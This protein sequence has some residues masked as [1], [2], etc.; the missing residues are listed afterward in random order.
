MLLIV[1]LGGAK[2]IYGPLIGAALLV[3]LPELLR[4]AN[5]Y[6]EVIYA[7]LV[8]VIVVAFPGGIADSRRLVMKV[9]RRARSK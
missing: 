9:V 8:L 4:D 3:Y 1:L 6:A 7:V 5:T 2:S